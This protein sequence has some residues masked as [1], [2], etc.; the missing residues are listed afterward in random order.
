MDD[1]IK[2]F[3]SPYKKGDLITQDQAMQLAMDVAKLGAPFV[4]PNP[5]VGCVVVNENHQYVNFGFHQKYG[6]D[7]AEVDALKK[8]SAA[9]INDAIFY[10]TL[11]P[12]AHEGKTPSCA[13]T[14]AKVPIKKVIFGLIDPNPLVA[15]KGAKILI[16][17]GIQAV[18][19]QGELKNK[20]NEVCE[21]FLKNFTEKK[22]FIAAKIASS[23]DGQ[24][25]L[26]SGE[27]KWI[28]SEAS[29]NFVHEL[30]S[31]YDAILVGR[32]TIEVDNPSLNIRHPEIT[33]ESKIIIIDPSSKILEKI[34]KGAEFRFLQLNNKKNIY[35]AVRKS[36]QA[37]GFQQIEFSNLEMLTQKLWQIGLRSIFIEGGAKT[38]S[39]FLE[40]KLIDRI[41]LFLAPTIIGGLNGL[42][43]A[44]GFGISSL[45]HKINFKSTDISKFGNDILITGNLE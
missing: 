6:F 33:K 36:N 1:K 3:I 15:G 41:Y 38:Y 13:K 40:A 27:S 29:R 30:R 17:A 19:Y 11:E 5:L 34:S 43:W 21:I 32:N 4:S 26:K 12:C 2:K 25:A 28:T 45:K 42:S 20:L 16:E 39:F 24:I 8:L 35:F 22:I 37:Y 23:L 7:H 44:S 9:E 31:Y 10:V 18:E 14:L